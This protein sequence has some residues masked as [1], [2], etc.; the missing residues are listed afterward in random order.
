MEHYLTA[1]VSRAAVSFNLR[2]I[3]GRL[4]RRCALC[5]VVKADAYGHHL[6]GL[7]PTIAAKADAMAVATLSEAMDLRDMGYEGRLLTTIACGA[8]S[9][10][11]LLEGAVEAGRRGIELTI[12]D[13]AD[14]RALQ[15]RAAAAGVKLPV[16][17]KIDT[18]MGRS[19]VLPADAPALVQAVREATALRL[20]GVCTH[21]AASDEADKAYTKRQFA[22]F[23][24]ILETLGDLTGVVRHAAN[25][26]A[27]TDLPATALDMVRVGL[28]V[29][30][31][32]A[33]DEL[34]DPLPLRPAL[35]LSGPIVQAKRLPAGAVCGYGRTCKLERPTR[36]GIIPFGYA[37][38]LPRTLSSRCAA[39]A[40]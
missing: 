34:A 14:V 25:S 24:R 15:R 8:Q 30:G 13:P 4:P 3:R 23:T 27:A 20:A 1:E 19:G 11:A 2:C 28:A 26:A 33:G 39:T 38:G 21:F 16:H 10:G 6:A 29:Y 18:G 17:V 35:R 40:G 5:A 12:T 7:W 32:P 22:T 36:I 37:D 9:G 31:Y